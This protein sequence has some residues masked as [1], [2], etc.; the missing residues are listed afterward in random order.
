VFAKLI[1]GVLMWTPEISI[2]K[3]LKIFPELNNQ[4]PL[5]CLCGKESLNIKPFVIKNW[6]GLL[7]DDCECGLGR[8]S[9]SVPRNNFLNNYL[10]NAILKI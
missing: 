8:S 10:I 2:N 4:F 6:I 1:L 3:W 5:K 9:I 7:S